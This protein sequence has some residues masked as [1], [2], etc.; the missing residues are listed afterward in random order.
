MTTQEKLQHFYDI[1]IESAK[2]EASSELEN[3]KKTLDRMFEEHKQEKEQQAANQLKVEAENAKR[4]IN[5]AL[6]AEQL[7]IKRRLSKKQQ[8]LRDEIFTEVKNMVESFVGTSE[9]EVWLED[10]IKEAK[11][12]AGNDTLEIFLSPAD[13]GYRESL[14]ARTGLLISM[15]ETPFMG[16]IIATIP[17][18]NILIDNSF[19]TLYENAREEFHFDGGLRHE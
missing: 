1:S 15:S 2:E 13:S 6:S 17:S 11:Q 7:H 12:L 14:M 10:K 9:Y 19:K 3:Y 4:E 8:A 5:K 18:K 16:G